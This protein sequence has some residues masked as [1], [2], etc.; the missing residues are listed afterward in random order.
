MNNEYINIGSPKCCFFVKMSM[1]I[2]ILLE[3][4]PFLYYAVEEALECAK[5]D[6]YA[7]GILAF[8]QLLNALNEKTPKDRHIIAHKILRNKPT[9]E[10]YEEIKA[11]VEKAADDININEIK[12]HNN[13]K[14]YELKIEKRWRDLMVKLN[15]VG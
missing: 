8:S 11:K 9:K 2:M 7:S 6:Y 4:N 10:M 1:R 12:K 13:I 14:E 3:N 15:P 5:N